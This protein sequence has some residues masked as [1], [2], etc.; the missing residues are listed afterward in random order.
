MVA[1][2]AAQ[3]FEWTTVALI[4]ACLSFLLGVALVSARAHVS[5][6]RSSPELMDFDALWW[7]RCALQLAALAWA[8]AQ[9]LPLQ[10][11]W[12]TPGLF[13][14]LT[15]AWQSN[16][17]RVYLILSFGVAEPLF[18]TLAL[19]VT[20]RAVALSPAVAQRSA[21]RL[22]YVSLLYAL[23]ICVVQTAIALYDLGDN[24]VEGPIDDNLSDDFVHSF[25]YGAGTSSHLSRQQA[26]DGDCPEGGSGCCCAFCTV[27][28]F[29]TIAS[30][31]HVLLWLVGLTLVSMQLARLVVNR[32]LLK[33]LR[34]LQILLSVSLVAGLCVR[35]GRAFT[36]PG[37]AGS[38]TLGLVYAG[39]VIVATVGGVVILALRPVMDATAL[40]GVLRR[41]DAE[42]RLLSG[43]GFVGE[44]PLRGPDWLALADPDSAP[45]SARIEMQPQQQQGSTAAAAATISNPLAMAAASPV[46][47]HA[48]S[49]ASP[50]SAERTPTPPGA[51]G[52]ARTARAPARRE[53]AFDSL[54]EREFDAREGD[55]A[56]AEQPEHD[57]GHL[58][59]SAEPPSDRA[60]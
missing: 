32:A 36:T 27:P 14:S 24:P 22:V 45:A 17:C 26:G 49:E 51:K 44:T 28:L 10:V 18:I 2:A 25:Q 38:T 19:L 30:A 48:A 41:E 1:G 55:S 46:V 50:P 16:L 6:R 58:L 57:A 47:L 7:A 3:A 33:R 43:S 53:L 42:Q 40:V 8:A 21:A 20:R 60:A 15:P 4:A 59:P 54:S 11:L 39:C 56:R 37:S 9:L 5:I 13:S 12:G 23:P 31:V 29:S 52:A 34:T 35:L